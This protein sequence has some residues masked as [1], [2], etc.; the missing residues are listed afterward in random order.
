[1]ELDEL[2]FGQDVSERHKEKIG[3]QTN[4]IIHLAQRRSHFVNI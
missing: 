3:H 4:I 1:M 2:L